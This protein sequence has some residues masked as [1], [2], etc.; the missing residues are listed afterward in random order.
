[1][2][3]SVGVVGMLLYINI[4]MPPILAQGCHAHNEHPL[5]S[6][7]H[8]MDCCYRG[9]Q[10]ALSACVLDLAG[11]ARGCRGVGSAAVWVL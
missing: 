9:M 5:P 11:D 3:G 8:S 6:C 10:F 1:M 4:C 7:A 2:S